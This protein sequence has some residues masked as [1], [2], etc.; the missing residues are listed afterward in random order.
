MCVCVCGIEEAW[1][2][3]FVQHTRDRR[4]CDVSLSADRRGEECADGDVWIGVQNEVCV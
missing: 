4:C 3:G 2:T 1:K